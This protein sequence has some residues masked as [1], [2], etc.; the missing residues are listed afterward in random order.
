MFA[1]ARAGPGVVFFN[2]NRT[3][4]WSENFSFYKSQIIHFITFFSVLL[5]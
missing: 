5:H 4:S 1:E 2:E 3:R